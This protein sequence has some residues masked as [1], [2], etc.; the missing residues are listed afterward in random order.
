MTCE[1]QILCVSEVV[2]E[3]AFLHPE[4]GGNLLNSCTV[5]AKATECLGGAFENVD[6]RGGCGRDVPRLGPAPRTFRWCAGRGRA[7]ST[8]LV[9][10]AFRL[11]GVG[12]VTSRT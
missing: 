2:V 6:A 5:I 1:Q 4:R 10:Q 9:E 8:T 3:I 11:N 7:H 12:R